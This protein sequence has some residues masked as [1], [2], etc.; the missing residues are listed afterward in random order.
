MEMTALADLVGLDD[1]VEPAAMRFRAK[2]GK[3]CSG[4]L[5]KGQRARVCAEATRI[6]LRAEL[7][8]C[9]DG[10]VYVPILT[11][12]RQLTIA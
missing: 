4:C 8:D 6:A 1:P 5:F 2:P 3:S 10:F 11:D 9:D 12:P 7:P